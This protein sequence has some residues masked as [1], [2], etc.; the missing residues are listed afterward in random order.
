MKSRFLKPAAWVVL[1]IL[2]SMNCEEPKGTTVITFME[3]Y[4]GN[5]NDFGHSVQQTFDGGYVITGIGGGVMLIK[6]DVSGDTL[7]T[8]TF[9][10]TGI[11]VQ[12]TRDGGYII[13]GYTFSL[14]AGSADVWLIK[15]DEYGNVE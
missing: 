9:P 6:T 8:R 14:G 1:G 10:G 4:G 13:T 3:T 12:Q 7:W 11:S 5:G 15:T 2:L